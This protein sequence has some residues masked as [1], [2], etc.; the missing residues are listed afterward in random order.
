MDVIE[1]FLTF[2]QISQ[3]R[4]ERT[5]IKYRNCLERLQAFLADRGRQ[6]LEAT[7]ADLEEFT[8]L[9][10]HRE[11]LTARARR[12]MVAAVRQFYGWAHK[13]RLV[14]ENPAADIEYP[15][16]GKRLPVPMQLHHA[17]RLLQ[18][19]DLTTFGGVRDAAMLALLLGCGLR[20]SGLVALNESDL[21]FPQH[22]GR[23]WLVVRI[24]EKGGKERL[25]PAPHEARLLV[26]AYLGHELLE[27]I[28]R[29]LPN[30]DRVLFVSV[31]NRTISPDRYHG[32]ERRISVRSVRE[33]IVTYGERAG[34]P[35]PELHPHALRHTYG[36]ELTESDVP[37]LVTTALMGHS[38]ASSTEIYTHLA[39]RKLMDVV[40]KGNPLGKIQTPVT[41]LLKKL[42]T[43]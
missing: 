13:G 30:G 20:I 11:K 41:A 40:A 7:R 33:M 28:D 27:E 26:R 34:I 23:E 6:L 25:V 10:L 32:E 1:A 43:A 19:P 39:M 35:R 31:N 16:A 38:D 2:K 3:G 4:A 24:R 21:L 18:Q 12:P 37:T 22:E 5:A 14:A 8:G 29:S 42:E 15:K 9:H 36:T 17:E